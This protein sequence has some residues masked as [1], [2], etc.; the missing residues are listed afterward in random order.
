MSP[1]S[2][3]SRATHD[4]ERPWRPTASVLTVGSELVEGLR[5]DTNT[6]EVAFAL[7]STG[8]RVVETVSVADDV[9]AVARS[10]ERLCARDAL[11]VVTG[12]LG[13]THD[14]VTR[15]AA[16]RALGLGLHPDETLFADLRRAATRHRDPRAAEQVLRQADVLEGALVIAP[17]TG[18]APGQVVS[19][20]AGRLALLPGPPAEMRPMLEQ[21]VS[22]IAPGPGRAAH[23]ELGCVGI[24][25]SDAQV[26]A[27]EVLA[28]AS[29]IDF[30]ILARPGDVRII[31]LDA[32][33]GRPALDRATD[34]VAQA[35][36]E[37]V[38][39]TDESTLPEAVL[40]G[41]RSRAIRVA[42]AESCTGGMVAA[43]LTDI[44]GSSDVLLGGIVAYS[45]M[46]KTD[47]LGVDP[48]VLDRYGAVSS[49]TAEAMAD[50]ARSELRAD[51]AV[52]VTGVAGP[53]GGTAE[54][55]V[56]LV[57]FGVSSQRG[58]HSTSHSFP[59][60]RSAIRIRATSTALD[61]LRREIAEW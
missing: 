41:A 8:Y 34:D 1:Q 39:A 56:G 24:T 2:D 13:P 43:A 45:N 14:D 55:P 58:T 7:A 57:W 27:S 49:E 47:L 15:E 33:A 21:L 50:G 31:L 18:T 40:D 12:G 35:L 36:S 10:L 26:R 16:G 52:A 5:V 9:D 11:V 29:G 28:G 23:R 53:G 38:Y 42:V 4:A 59:G 17:V 54:K 32:G 20:P 19:T 51:V 30:T 44:A 6:R 60:D 46:A 22:D 37:H 48:H 3:P 25:E 61:L